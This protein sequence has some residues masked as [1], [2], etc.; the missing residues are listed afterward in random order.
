VPLALG[1]R[2]M[3]AEERFNPVGEV[4]SLFPVN[5]DDQGRTVSVAVIDHNREFVEAIRVPVRLELFG[6]TLSEIGED[7]SEDTI[8]DSPEIDLGT[9]SR[10]R[11]PSLTQLPQSVS[12]A[13]LENRPAVSPT[14]YAVISE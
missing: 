3:I 14:E 8:H 13:L 11:P 6:D 9:V 5:M 2:T 4:G 7:R 10:Y 1:T 12:S